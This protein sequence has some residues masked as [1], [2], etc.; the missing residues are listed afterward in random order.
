MYTEP[1]VTIELKEYND[2]KQRVEDLE[3]QSG[4]GGLNIL[5]H[6]EGIGLLLFRALNNPGL[7]RGKALTGEPVDLGKY[8]ALITSGSDRDNSLLVSILRKV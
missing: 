6:Q 4:V 5:E 2:L 7:F 1:M 3:K 8:K